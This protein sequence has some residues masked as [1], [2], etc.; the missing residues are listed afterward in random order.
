M[1]P[2]TFARARI[3][4]TATRPAAWDEWLSA[5]GRP[6]LAL[7]GHER[8]E[9]FY[10]LIQAA[11]CGLGMAL[12]PRFLVEDEI[13]RGHV[14]APFGFVTGPHDLSLWIAPHMRSRGDVRRLSTEQSECCNHPLPTT[15]IAWPA[16][17][18][19]I[20]VA[21]WTGV[22]ASICSSSISGR[23]QPPGSTTFR[24]GIPR[25]TEYEAGV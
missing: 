21:N 3:L 8:Y 16:E 19:F 14:V 23:L 13:R 2:K 6:D 1:R 25:Q 4:G 7:V 15:V 22:R 11:A 9:H 20:P 24:V 18:D 12:A 5:I 17:R 10:L